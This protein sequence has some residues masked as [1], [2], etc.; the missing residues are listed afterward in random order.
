MRYSRASKT[1][2]RVGRIYLKFVES[3]GP[4]MMPRVCR[5]TWVV[6]EVVGPS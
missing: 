6:V 4:Q 1:F 3:R 2:C 5:E